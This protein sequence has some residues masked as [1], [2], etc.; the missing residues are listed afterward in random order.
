MLG[1]CS[2]SGLR[3][4]SFK[5]VRNRPPLMDE[6]RTRPELEVE[7]MAPALLG[8]SKVQTFLEC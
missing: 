4:H 2:C 5:T 7:G 6:E 8:A 1:E 3:W